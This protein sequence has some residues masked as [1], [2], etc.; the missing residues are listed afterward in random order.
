MQATRQQI[1]EHL[2]RERTATVRALVDLTGLTAAAVRQHL[3]VLEREGLVQ[4][5]AERGHVG[6]PARIYTLTSRGEALYPTSHDLLATMLMQEL[7]AAGPEILQRIMQRIA[8]RM[9]DQ[10]ME[11]VAGRP[12]AE[13]VQ[14]TAAILR[15]LGSTVES[16]Q[17]GDEHFIFQ[18]TCPYPTVARRNS[19]VCALEVDFVRRLTGADA[20]LVTSLLRGDPA[21]TYRIRPRVETPAPG[22]G[23]SPSTDQAGPPPA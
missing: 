22:R 2:H 23:P 13:R 18:C 5:R 17:R 8:A 9:A 11:R 1:V 14:E 19:A 12:V 21:C 15:E 20:H 6:R 7:R 4:A 16:E 10:R 3:A